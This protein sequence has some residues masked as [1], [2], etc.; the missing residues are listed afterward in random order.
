MT[1][2]YNSIYFDCNVKY[3]VGDIFKVPGHYRN[4]WRL[5]KFDGLVIKSISFQFGTWLHF[6]PTEWHKS[7]PKI[8]ISC[9]KRSLR[10]WEFL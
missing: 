9:P 10:G 3:K 6:D 2:N 5:M 1:T 8:E 4:N 7:E